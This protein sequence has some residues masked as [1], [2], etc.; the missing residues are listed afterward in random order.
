MRQA[1]AKVF[2]LCSVLMQHSMMTKRSTA[3]PEWRLLYSCALLAIQTSPLCH[4]PIQL[5]SAK[6]QA[7]APC[8]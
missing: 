2:E 5:G 3:C 7:F 1:S 6:L 8:D 4:K